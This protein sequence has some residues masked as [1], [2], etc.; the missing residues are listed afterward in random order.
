MAYRHW[1]V[2]GCVAAL[3]C[4]CGSVAFAQVKKRPALEGKS[5]T[6]LVPLTEISAKDRY[7]GE[8]GG[9]YGGGRNQ[10]PEK[11]HAAAKKETA[12]IRPLNEKGK[13]AKDGKIALVS[14]S[15]SNA[16]QVFSLF[17]SIADA[18]SEKSAL[19][20]IVDCA[21][22]G[23]AMA[24]W[25][26]PR[27]KPWTEAERRLTAAK[28]TP[29]QVQIAWIKLANKV[30][31][32]DLREHGKRLQKDTLAV[33]HNAR[34]RFPNLRIVYLGSRTYAGYATGKL[35]PEPYAYESAFVVRWLIQDQIKGDASLNY[36]PARGA[37]KSPLLLWGPYL[38][39]D[40]VT[41]RKSDGLV[42]ERTDV[43][44]DGVHPSPSGRRKAAEQLLRFFKTDPLAKTWFV[45]R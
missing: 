15:M 4:G 20:T 9:L 3:W 38:W 39:T 41:P 23:Q 7:K 43:A 11:H 29:Q 35:N 44:A 26:D 13:P 17:K 28:I 24:E 1:L 36:D 10:P 31:S 45:G 12:Q 40:G 37:V 8:D 2:L 18:D 5:S 6:G 34:A 22:G 25:A 33:L 27:A 16:T 21:Q 42:W 19:L 14:I 32:G 30:P